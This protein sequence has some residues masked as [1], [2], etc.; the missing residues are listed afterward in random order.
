MATGLL[1]WS[2]LLLAATTPADDVT[3]MGVRGFQI[4]IRIQPD[5]LPQV[6]E[7]ILYV[8]RDKGSTWELQTQAAPTSKAFDFFA[9]NDGT[10]MFT[11]AV[12]D[13]KGKQDP[14]DPYKVP[15]AQKMKV[16]VDTVKPVAK[17]V[18]ADRAGD[19]VQV[20]WEVQEL[21][22]QWASFK[23]LWR[24]ADAPPTQW[25]PLPVQPG[26]RG[27]HKFRPNVQGDV[28]VRLQVQ[29]FAENEGSDEKTV[30]RGGMTHVDR[31]VSRASNDGLPA[32][33]SAAAPPVA[34]LTPPPPPDITPPPAITNPPRTNNP[35]LETAIG[36][37]TAGAAPPISPT[38][39]R[40]PLPPHRII[41]QKQVKVGFEVT[42]YGPSGLGTVDVYVTKD[43]GMTWEKSNADP[44]VPLPV[45]PETP[46]N[47][48]V[49]G[50]VT[51]QI[52]EE[53]KIY[54][55]FLV[56]KS[57]A[58]LSKQPPRSGDAP[59]IRVECDTTQPAAELYAP[60]ADPARGTNLILSW[61]AEDRNLAQNPI[62]LEWSPNGT[63]W[64]FI[65]DVQHPNTGRYTWQVPAKIPAKVHLKLTVR[66]A[67]GNVAVAQTNEPVVIDL[68]VPEVGG[69]TILPGR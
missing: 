12:R 35:P 48:P 19:E 24:A 58:Q 43:E 4:P 66:D 5:R 42:R 39:P 7:L 17:L 8:S 13:K 23:L 55:F 32:L 37:S 10:Y 53:G 18:Q 34:G 28:V 57:R 16:N 68:T 38:P 3:H 64:E 14:P 36:S 2:A 60:Q 44:N 6:E 65:G 69:V 46:G 61:K 52:P 63:T 9:P 41:N 67:A 25:T 31:N 29:D 15:D 59:Q 20:T 22:P 54:G 47:G 21:F 45:T 11:V 49:K 62:S 56:V 40:G 33:A 26:E 1:A 51:V 27:S 30:G 50:T